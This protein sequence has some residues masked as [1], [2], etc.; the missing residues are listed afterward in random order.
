MALGYPELDILEYSDGSWDIIQY[1]QS[2]TV[3]CLTQWQMVL[4]TFKNVEKS[5]ALCQKYA[6]E[7]DIERKQFWA[8]EEAATKAVED[9]WQARERHAEDSAELATQ[10]VVR[11]PNL[12]NRIGKNGLKEMDLTSIAR[13]IPR[14]EYEKPVFRGNNVI[15]NPGKSVQ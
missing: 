1:Y 8:R 3:P 10:A 12:M 7:L 4:G 11:N 6:Q 2:P 9:E 5:F 14:S 13:H 15:H